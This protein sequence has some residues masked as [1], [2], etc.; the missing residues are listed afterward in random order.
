MQD[1][2][3]KDPELVSRAEALE[4]MA[5]R[6]EALPE[7]LPAVAAMPALVELAGE[8]FQMCD[9]A[10]V[11]SSF[12]VFYQT[13][14]D[15]KSEGYLWWSMTQREGG[16]DRIVDLVSMGLARAKVPPEILRSVTQYDG[17]FYHLSEGNVW[18]LRTLCRSLLKKVESVDEG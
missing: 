12:R 4:A 2:K 5:A 11:Q 15:G 6:L 7:N 9:V 14:Y 1:V 16:H 18:T 8:L 17:R 13:R 10:E 3:T